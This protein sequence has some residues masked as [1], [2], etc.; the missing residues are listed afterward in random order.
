MSE[1][2]KAR[3]VCCIGDI[4]GYITKLQNL[5]SNLENSIDPSEFKTATIIFLG[6]YCDRGPQTREVIDFLVALPSRYPNQRHVFIAGN[7]DFAFAAFLRLLPPPPDGSE[8]S[9]GWK[10]FE[11]SEDREGWFKSDGYE[12]MHLQGRRWAGN[13]KDKDNIAK[14][15]K[16][17]GSIYDAGPTFESYGVPHGSPGM[18]FLIPH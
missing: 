6:D 2:P 11:K 16:Y 17:Q 9:E 12:K 13:I 4:H 18:L 15:T 1:S 7:H 8:F 14:G 5:W 3:I 10:E